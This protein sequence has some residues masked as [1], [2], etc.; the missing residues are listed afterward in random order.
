MWPC[1]RPPHAGLP[2]S[3]IATAGKQAGRRTSRDITVASWHAQVSRGFEPRSLDSESRVLTVTPRDQLHSMQPRWQKPPGHGLGPPPAP[4]ARGGHGGSA[5]AHPRGGTH[6][7]AGCSWPA[8]GP[9]LVLHGHPAD[10]GPGPAAT[11]RSTRAGATVP[12][13]GLRRGLRGRSRAGL[14]RI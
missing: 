13:P 5:R 3:R 6:A 9:R 10:S 2:A 12:G 7:A 4:A 14:A 8:P 1:A 11:G